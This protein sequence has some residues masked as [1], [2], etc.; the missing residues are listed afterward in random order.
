MKT[1][2]VDTNI[3]LEVLV[4]KGERSD[5]CLTMLESEKNLWTTSFVIAEIEWVLRSGYELKRE[6]VSFYL[7]R[8]FSLPGLKIE[9]RKILLSVLDIYENTNIDWVDCVNAFLLNKKGVKEVYSYDKHYDKFD[10]V[11]RKEP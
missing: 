11:E 5:R 7:K 9:N 4:R 1:K 8:I 2:F 3:F 6:E 10:W